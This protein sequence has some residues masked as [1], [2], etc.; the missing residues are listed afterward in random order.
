MFKIIEWR[1]SHSND[2]WFNMIG[3]PNRECRTPGHCRV[4]PW[5]QARQKENRALTWDHPSYQVIWSCTLA[6]ADPLRILRALRFAARFTFTVDLSLQEAASKPEVIYFLDS[7]CVSTDHFELQCDVDYFRLIQLLQAFLWYMETSDV[8][9]GL[10][11]FEQS[12]SVGRKKF[13]G[14]CPGS[15]N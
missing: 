15:E 1:G 11:T 9:P 10:K 2:G 8:R 5:W 3:L 14:Q 7:F 13:I 6:C 12:K 4:K